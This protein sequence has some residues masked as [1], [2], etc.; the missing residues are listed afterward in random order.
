[1]VSRLWSES[2]DSSCLIAPFLPGLSFC[3]LREHLLG[4]N[5]SNF[6]NWP[7]LCLAAFF[8]KHSLPYRPLL[9][10]QLPLFPDRMLHTRIYASNCF[11]SREQ[12]DRWSGLVT[13]LRNKRYQIKEVEVGNSGKAD[14]VERVVGR[15]GIEKMA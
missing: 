1:M 10:W 7:I 14:G 15:S 9:Y 8:F 3:S 4:Y 11:T 5:V 12:Y 6:L 13:W 2:S